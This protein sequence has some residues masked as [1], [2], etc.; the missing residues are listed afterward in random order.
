MK[1]KRDYVKEISLLTQ[2]L[3]E[4]VAH[5]LQMLKERTD[6]TDKEY[7]LHR[8]WEQTET[9]KIILAKRI[10]RKRIGREKNLDRAAESMGVNRAEM[11]RRVK[12]VNEKGIYKVT[13]SIYATYELF[14]FEGKEL[15]DVLHLFAR[16]KE[17]RDS[18]DVKFRKID[19]GQLEYSDIETDLAE[20]YQIFK[21]ITP[22]SR[23]EKLG[24]RRAIWASRICFP[25]G[26]P[27]EKP[28]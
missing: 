25:I 20:M 27:F 10:V 26:R 7:F 8:L 13:N 24:E 2:R 9:Q 3:Y 16:R 17:L 28:S 5:E 4:D 21:A 18:L 15:D 12:A 23:Y 22:E 1:K 19:Q 14:R 6:I 11:R